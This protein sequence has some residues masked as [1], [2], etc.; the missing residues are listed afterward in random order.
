MWWSACS[1]PSGR[2]HTSNI[3]KWSEL[4]YNRYHKAKKS[5]F[6]AHGSC[7]S[8]VFI[9]KPLWSVM[10]ALTKYCRFSIVF[11]F[12]KKKQNYST[13]KYVGRNPIGMWLTFGFSLSSWRLGFP[14]LF[15]GFF[16]IFLMMA[17]HYS[18][19]CLFVGHFK[20]KRTLLYCERPPVG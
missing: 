17:C 12:Q 8:V 10:N 18:K 9:L 2:S 5:I 4:H 6:W 20:R 19:G 1:V 7:T 14:F 15:F 13:Q 11:S 16:F 3:F